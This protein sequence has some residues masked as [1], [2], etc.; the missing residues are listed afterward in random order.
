VDVGEVVCSSL[1]VRLRKVG[2]FFPAE[3]AGIAQ[4]T[5]RRLGGYAT[6]GVEGGTKIWN[7]SARP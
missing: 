2:K 3:S 7:G 6:R 1:P 4:G 5:V